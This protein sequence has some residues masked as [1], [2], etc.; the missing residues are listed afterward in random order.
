MFWVNLWR[1]QDHIGRAHNLKE[2]FG[3]DAVTAD[4]S[5]PWDA[6]DVNPKKTLAVIKEKWACDT[7]RAEEIWDQ[8]AADDPDFDNHEIIFTTQERVR[9]W[10]RIQDQSSWRSRGQIIIERKIL[11]DGA[12]IFIDDPGRSDFMLLAP[13]QEN[14]VNA[15]IEGKPLEQVQIGD[16]RYFVRPNLFHLDSG[17]YNAKLIFTR[18]EMITRKLIEKSYPDIYVP[19]LICYS[20]VKPVQRSQLC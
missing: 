8:A 3:V 9:A 10:G 19:K 13:Y 5:H 6:G 20:S 15:R 17:L 4:G 1:N 7:E 14:Y 12:I 2:M 16:F 18:T 11:P